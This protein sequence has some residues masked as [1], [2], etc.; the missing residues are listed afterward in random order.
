[1]AATFNWSCANCG[2]EPSQ[3]AK[4]FEFQD[5]IV[6]AECYQQ[7]RVAPA[8][9]TTASDAPTALRD[10]KPIQKV[11]RTPEANSARVCA[12]CDQPF[13]KLEQPHKWN[14]HFVCADCHERLS[15]PAKRRHT[16]ST[17]LWTIIGIFTVSAVVYTAFIV[18]RAATRASLDAQKKFAESNET[19]ERSRALRRNLGRTDVDTTGLR[20]KVPLTRPLGA[21]VTDQPVVSD[22]WPGG[23]AAESNDIVDGFELVG[24]RLKDGHV[25]LDASRTSLVKVTG[26]VSRF[27]VPKGQKLVQL[28]LH[29]VLPG[30][31]VGQAIDF[32]VRAPQQQWVLNDDAGGQYMPVGAVAIASAGGTETLEIQY[33]VNQENLVAG[34]TLTRWRKIAD[35][36]LKTQPN[37]KLIF[38]YLVPLRCSPCAGPIWGEVKIVSCP[39]IPVI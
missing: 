15:A 27:D 22:D 25:V 28:P 8:L 4:A 13:G 14:T 21:N 39:P 1:M 16:R 20:V 35:Q 37:A 33:H 26:M 2:R 36:D 23:L 29:R 18:P 17:I 7:L 10:P 6:C 32:A 12:N 30:G 9:A 38:L 3:L 19:L 34:Q 11:R 31:L 5:K 24:S